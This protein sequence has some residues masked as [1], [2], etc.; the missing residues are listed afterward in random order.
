MKKLKKFLRN[1][2]MKQSTIMNYSMTAIIIVLMFLGFLDIFSGLF[3][4]WVCVTAL[5]L[6]VA[7][8]CLVIYNSHLDTKD[9]N[10]QHLLNKLK[11]NL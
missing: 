3:F 11:K 8:I 10:Q 5:I 6:L 7:N 4:L 9:M 2:G 1:F